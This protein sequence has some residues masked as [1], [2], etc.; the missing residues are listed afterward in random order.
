MYVYMYVVPNSNNF[1]EKN[2]FL[3]FFWGDCQFHPKYRKLG[4]EMSSRPVPPNDAKPENCLYLKDF[5]KSIEH[6]REIRNTKKLARN[7]DKDA[8]FGSPCIFVT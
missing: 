2:T 4:M 5:Q 8:C 6:G 3:A 1:E 7:V